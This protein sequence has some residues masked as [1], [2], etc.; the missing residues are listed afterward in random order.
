MMNMSVIFSG[1]ADEIH[2]DLDK[3][4]EL[5]HK[6]GM[7][8][9]CLRNADGRNIGETSF[10]QFRTEH[11]PRLQA[12]GIKISSF[13]T[14]IGK[15]GLEDEAAF[16]KQ[17]DQ[18]EEICRM[19]ELSGTQYLRVFSFYPPEG[20]GPDDCLAAAVVR[21][22]ELAD[23]AERYGCVMIHENE[24]DIIGDTADRCLALL[25][26]VDKPGFKAAFDFAN[27]VQVGEDPQ[28]A[29]DELKDYVVYIH[30]KDS[31]DAG[32][33]VLAGTGEGKIEAI[34]RQAIEGGYKGFLTL[35]PHLA[36]FTGF[37]A[38]E[39]EGAEH[40]D[41]LQGEDAGAQ[42]FTMQYQAVRSM[43]ERIVK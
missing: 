9:L 25:K 22:K 6:L 32:K 34:L 39:A 5:L 36:D 26:A 8:Y 31:D 1:F 40:P 13:G 29:W 30:I 23:I 28:A 12:A 18:L 21:L 15:I 14:P 20:A 27:F 2:E 10:E 17:K 43:L 35:E 37:T 41:T 11:W 42:G 19:A 38:L 4:I 33:N 7:E 3:Q 24:K 16:A